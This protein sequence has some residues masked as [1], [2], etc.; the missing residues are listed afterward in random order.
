MNKYILDR[1]SVVHLVS[2]WAMGLLGIKGPLAW[3]LV[4]AYDAIEQ[5]IERGPNPFGS[6]QP[7]TFDNI[8]GDT[9]LWAAGYYS[10]RAFT[11]RRPPHE[12]PV[13]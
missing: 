8:L 2:G 4:I 3:S 6:G 5:A 9:I 10:A 7:E 13:H 12:D 1:W 11:K